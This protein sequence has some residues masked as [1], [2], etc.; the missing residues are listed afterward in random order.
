MY[1]YEGMTIDEILENPDIDLDSAEAHYALAQC[2]RDE[3]SEKF[4]A[5]AYKEH[6]SIA[7]SLGDE[8]ALAELAELSVLETKKS[9]AEI[10]KK[11]SFGEKITMTELVGLA[12]QGD[13]KACLEI[14]SYCKKIG[15]EKKAEEYIALCVANIDALKDSNDKIDVC[16]S[17][18][19]IYKSTDEKQYREMLEYAR[20]LG[21]SEAVFRLIPV[22][23]NGI[24]GVEKKDQAIE[25]R[26]K[27]VTVGTAFQ[28]YAIAQDYMAR[29]NRFDAA[30]VLE[31]ILSSDQCDDSIR[32]KAELKMA[33][34]NRDS[35]LDPKTYISAIKK[36]H[37]DEDLFDSIMEM[38]ASD[39]LGVDGTLAKELFDKANGDIERQKKVYVNAIHNNIDMPMTEEE[40]Q[41]VNANA[42]NVSSIGSL[43]EL[44]LTDYEALLDRYDAEIQ[45]VEELIDVIR[46]SK[47]DAPNSLYRLGRYIRYNDNLEYL[48]EAAKECEEADEILTFVAFFGQNSVGLNL[49]V[50]AADLGDDT[51]IMMYAHV[52]WNEGHCQKALD[53]VRPLARK[54]NEYAQLI[55]GFLCLNMGDNEGAVGWLLPIINDFPEAEYGLYRARY[56][57][58]PEIH[59]QNAVDK[60]LSVAKLEQI[61]KSVIKHFN[62]DMV[63]AYLETKNAYSADNCSQYEASIGV[64]NAAILCRI[65]S[66]GKDYLL[67]QSGMSCEKEIENACQNLLQGGYVGGIHLRFVSTFFLNRFVK[68][69]LF[70]PDC[71]DFVTEDEYKEVLQEWKLSTNIGEQDVFNAFIKWINDSC[72]WPILFSDFIENDINSSMNPCEY[73]D[74]A[75]HLIENGTKYWANSEKELA[76]ALFL[77]A[78]NHKDY[79]KITKYIDYIY[80]DGL[81][82]DDI[83]ISQAL[84]TVDTSL[85]TVKNNEPHRKDIVIR[86]TEL[87]EPT[88]S[89]MYIHEYWDRD[90]TTDARISAIKFLKEKAQNGNKEAA[91]KL[92]SIFPFPSDMNVNDDILSIYQ[93][94][95]NS[96][97]EEAL[98]ILGKYF[99]SSCV[100]NSFSIAEALFNKAISQGNEEAKYEK[101]RLYILQGDK[102]QKEQGWKEL[103][104]RKNRYCKKVRK[105]LKSGKVVN[106]A[107]R[108][109]IYKVI[110]LLALNAIPI[111]VISILVV[112]FGVSTVLIGVLFLFILLLWIVSVLV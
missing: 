104:D 46:T 85:S 11:E 54:G 7:G 107:K 91:E 27:L 9:Q 47:Q 53:M 59:L 93:W 35:N 86:L 28:K 62:E 97:I 45:S 75:E 33:M 20:E 14:Y 100:S 84:S 16:L 36:G 58:K 77:T 25:C 108:R 57:L 90:D 67:L 5:D 15:D 111:A 39:L 2:Y 89:W 78:V 34:I 63:G 21:S 82:K 94:A 103:D 40:Y 87:G 88:A 3:K 12:E 80:Q 61:S 68:Y 102:E 101:A 4:D 38:W 41:I 106:Y 31:N 48:Y 10:E 49:I 70:K 6:L 95:S 37:V 60:N 73:Y 79:S 72:Y 109:K 51:A 99:T 26:K 44:S 56:G 96:G 13:P 1:M 8:K 30:V 29:G 74:K 55:T 43:S 112:C 65:L 19:E 64:I 105:E 83:E 69:N 52:K 24:G 66:V 42:Q 76:R 98:I 81:Y 17:L 50:M 92:V 23:E 18:A 32:M 71:V 22:Y 110:G